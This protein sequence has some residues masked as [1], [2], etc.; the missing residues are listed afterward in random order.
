MRPLAGN[1]QGLLESLTSELIDD[2]DRPIAAL[3][4]G[5][6]IV[7]RYK[8]ILNADGSVMNIQDSLILIA[9]ES[10]NILL[11]TRQKQMK[12][13]RRYRPCRRITNLSKK[14]FASFIL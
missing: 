14:A 9:Q 10:K 11:R 5:L 1:C 3:G 6:S 4:F 12:I 13:M 8:K 2:I 7:T